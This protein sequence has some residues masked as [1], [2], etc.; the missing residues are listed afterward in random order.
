MET[1][2][3]SHHDQLFDLSKVEDCLSISEQWTTNE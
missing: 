3:R 2:V 1:R